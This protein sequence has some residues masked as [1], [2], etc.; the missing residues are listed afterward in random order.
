MYP[1]APLYQDEY[2]MMLMGTNYQWLLFNMFSN[3]MSGLHYVAMTFALIGGVAILI[4]PMLQ[5]LRVIVP[6]LILAVIMIVGPYNNPAFFTL[7]TSL[8]PLPTYIVYPGQQ[9]Q[10]SYFIRCN[11]PGENVCASSTSPGKKINAALVSTVTGRDRVNTLMGG[12]TNVHGFAPQMAIIHYTNKIQALLAS[13]LL[14]GIPKVGPMPPTVT[15][16]AEM[17][18]AQSDKFTPKSPELQYDKDLFSRVCKS[19]KDLAFGETGLTADQMNA[20]GGDLRAAY[21]RFGFGS[22]DNTKTN[23]MGY[24]YFTLKD[25]HDLHRYYYEFKEQNS[26]AAVYPP[27]AE[28]LIALSAYGYT[29]PDIQSGDALDALILDYA[30]GAL[31]PTGAVVPG[32]GGIIADTFR[33][34]V[35][36]VSD[37]DKPYSPLR[38]KDWMAAKYYGADGANPAGTVAAWKAAA[39]MQDTFLRAQLA[40]INNKQPMPGLIYREP[41]SY[42]SM[43]VIIAGG[44]A[45]GD[46]FLGER[47]SVPWTNG[48]VF[49]IEKEKVP[50]LAAYDQV[51]K[52]YT[53]GS[54]KAVMSMPVAIRLPIADSQNSPGVADPYIPAAGSGYSAN[55]YNSLGSIRVTNCAEFHAA[56]NDKYYTAVSR[57]NDMPVDVNPDLN[58][59]G[60]QITVNGDG[61]DYPVPVDSVNA[62]DHAAINT[63]NTG[64]LSSVTSWV[65]SKYDAGVEKIKSYV[66]PAALTEAESAMKNI[67]GSGVFSAFSGGLAGIAE[68]VGG[69]LMTIVSKF[70]GVAAKVFLRFA[71]ALSNYGL[72]L[73]LMITPI[74]YLMGLVIP[75]WSLQIIAAPLAAVLYFKTVA[76]CAILIDFIIKQ[77]QDSQLIYETGTIE[78]ALYTF[79]AAAGY[80][81]VFGVAGFLLFGL[82]NAGSLVQQLGGKM[83][84]A[85]Q[86][87]AQGVAGTVT[88]PLLN[89]GSHLA[90]GAKAGVGLMASMKGAEIAGRR[91]ARKADPNATEEEVRA[92]GKEQRQQVWDASVDSLKRIPVIG[93]GLAETFNASKEAKS[94]LEKLRTLREVA[95]KTGGTAPTGTE[96]RKSAEDR[97]FAY[98]DQKDLIASGN[99]RAASELGL[100]NIQ[101]QA[102]LDQNRVVES[103]MR[104][105]SASNALNVDHSFKTADGRDGRID[106]LTSTLTTNS[107]NMRY[108]A[109]A[110]LKTADDAKVEMAIIAGDAQYNARENNME[111]LKQYYET[112]KDDIPAVQR[113]AKTGQILRDRDGKALTQVDSKGNTVYA[114][115]KGDIIGG[116]RATSQWATSKD[117]NVRKHYDKF[118]DM[119]TKAGLYESSYVDKAGNEFFI[120]GVEKAGS[121]STMGGT[122]PPP[123]DPTGGGMPGGRGDRSQSVSPSKLDTGDLGRVNRNHQYKSDG[124][125]FIDEK[126]KRSVDEARSREKTDSI[127]G[128]DGDDA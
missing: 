124:G 91:G 41:A 126:T 83:D 89:A 119:S 110:G 75:G 99:N 1:A 82:G 9:A 21:E 72:A 31:T 118:M 125:I 58:N 38:A 25:V 96:I 61:S 50:T 116:Y 11:T 7:G 39:D 86:Q 28:G 113:D 27:K 77:M 117:P 4:L 37:T 88:K 108:A 45:K 43:D 80:M 79:I 29:Y 106:G 2:L 104:A 109:A 73:S 30:P 101:G 71:I 34:Q 107:N 48:E 44:G 10:Y 123:K 121:G 5:T 115:R 69:W 78:Y 60:R 53:I 62:A 94:N 85:A 112:A 40:M 128:D 47:V 105:A 66:A 114:A 32:A 51:M 64:F 102:P 20:A 15:D 120:T 8:N 42:S 87:G 16:V 97:S 19:Y 57:Q 22:A 59:P 95:E 18:A 81:S 24:K 63:A 90:T 92:V 84:A 127:M 33:K 67:A 3:P 46:P 36:S 56:L 23:Q 100:K 70:I 17:D 68:W 76:I 55:N 49:A 14:K 13:S 54:M 35:F 26:G 65:G 111:A 6:F 103:H 74:I 93:A 122:P 52:K 12:G 98:R